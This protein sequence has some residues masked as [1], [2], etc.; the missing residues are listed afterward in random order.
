MKPILAALA[1]TSLALLAAAPARADTIHQCSGVGLEEREAAEQVP[2]NLR[3]VFAQADGHY[4]GGVETRLS[5]M[6]G[7][8]ILTVRCP[9]P[10]VLLNL[11]AGR[12][13]VTA[14]LGGVTQTRDIAVS[15]DRRQ[16]QVFRF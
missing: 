9:G 13:R 8:E 12:Y 15:G 7:A 5:D 16:K 6:A 4:L 1:A 2:H 10:W 3:L 11:P 14:S